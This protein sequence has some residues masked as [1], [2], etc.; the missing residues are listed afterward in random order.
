[1]VSEV[2]KSH[3]RE[4][5]KCA[6][7]QY[8]DDWLFMSRDRAVVAWATREFVRLCIRLGLM[9]NLEKSVLHP[10]RRLVHLGMLWDFEEAT[11]RPSDKRI[12]DIV[13]VAAR[14]SVASRFPLQLIE[15][16]MG[17]LVSVETAVPFGRLNYRAF[18]RLLVRELKFGRSFRWVKLPEEVRDN[19]RWWASRPN[20]TMSKSVRSP[21]PVMVIHTDASTAGWG[22]TADGATLKGVWSLQEK[23]LHINLLEMIAVKNTILSWSSVLKSKVICFRIDNVSVVYYLN[24]QGGTRS[25][26]LCREAE[27]VLRLAQSLNITIQASHIRG[28][29]NVLADMMSR[30]NYILKNE[31]RLAPETFRWVCAESVWGDPTIDLFANRLNFQVPRFLSP[32]QDRQA[33]GTDALLCR[34]PNEVCYAFPP[35]TLMQRVVEKIQQERPARLLLV[36]PWWPMV[37][38]FPTLQSR[39]TQVRPIPQAVLRL[40]QPHFRCDMHSPMLLSLA[41]WHISYRG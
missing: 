23:T 2:V 15:S 11:I 10:A 13:D 22:A 37:T 35:T 28:D 17:K 4:N 39:A 21:S 7:Y 38:W 8:I 19:L 33:V 3:V 18:Q 12:D 25:A 26:A 6:V 30:E 1:M 40:C 20:L 24:K 9:V 34:W 16:L 29:L 36:A 31:W 14:M 41:L 32:C 5:W 27:A